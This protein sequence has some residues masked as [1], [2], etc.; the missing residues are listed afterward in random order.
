MK[1]LEDEYWL[2]AAQVSTAVFLLLLLERE[3]KG[4]CLVDMAKNFSK[5]SDAKSTSIFNLFSQPEFSFM[6]FLL[7]FSF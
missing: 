6:F 3:H 7:F 2:S 4:S 5:A 1:F